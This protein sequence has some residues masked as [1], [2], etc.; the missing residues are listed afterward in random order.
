MHL[1][2][3]VGMKPLTDNE[4]QVLCGLVRHTSLSNRELGNELGMKYSTV[5]SIKHRLARNGYYKRKRIPFLQNLGCEML[6]VTY[7]DFNPAVSAEARVEKAREKIEIYD[8]LFYS[9]GETNSGFSLSFSKNYA[10]IDK[11]GDIRTQLFAELGLLEGNFPTQVIF[12]FETSDIVRFLD[13]SRLLAH[14][15]GIED[16]ETDDGKEFVKGDPVS[17]RK[18]ETRVLHALIESSDANDATIAGKTGLSK[19]TISNIR[20]KLEEGGLIRTITIPDLNKLG[21]EILC[22]GHTKL[23]PKCPY[24][25]ETFDMSILNTDSGIFFAAKRFENITLSIYRS[26]EDFKVENSAL[27]RY[28]KENNMIA[29]MP[30]VRLYSIGRMITIKDLVFGP[31]VKQLLDL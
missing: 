20:R 18:R 25:P 10:N 24:D 21:F 16:D 26:Y 8:E 23:S 17:L 13:Y 27:I 2:K 1:L 15:F 30:L 12:P 6:G 3:N 22:F 28:L 31:F 14:D 9:V 7:A 5:T 19:H 29:D 11:I 4:K